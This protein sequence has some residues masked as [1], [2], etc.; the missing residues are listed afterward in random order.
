M[1]HKIKQIACFLFQ[2]IKIKR[3]T[4][5]QKTKLML[6]TLESIFTTNNYER[7]N[8]VWND[9][10][11]QPALSSNFWYSWLYLLRICFTE[12]QRSST[13]FF[14]MPY[15]FIEISEIVEFYS[16]WTVSIVTTPRKGIYEYIGIYF[17]YSF[18]TLW[19]FKC[20]SIHYIGWGLI[21]LSRHHYILITSSN[22]KLFLPRRKSQR[23]RKYLFKFFF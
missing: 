8:Y 17:Q 14:N 2:K 12:K 16:T 7:E 15:F 1:G 11:K 18:Q 19:S 9:L 22:L 3:K 4:R 23:L 21:D 6:H 10:A 20:L 13:L 5:K